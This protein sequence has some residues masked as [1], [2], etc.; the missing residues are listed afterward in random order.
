[1]EERCDGTVDCEDGM[2]EEE[3][4]SLTTFDGYNKLLVPPPID[5]GSKFELNISM[6]IDDILNIDENNGYFKTKYSIIR[7]V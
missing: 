4:E 5:G 3:C 2:D 7:Q 6:I 1:M